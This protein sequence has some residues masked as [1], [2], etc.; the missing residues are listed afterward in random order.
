MKGPTLV[1]ACKNFRLWK[2]TRLKED[3]QSGTFDLGTV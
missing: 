1:M 3:L 2:G